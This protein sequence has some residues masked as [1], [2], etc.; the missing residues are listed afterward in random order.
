MK[1]TIILVDKGLFI[2]PISPKG[3]HRLEDLRGFL[4][5][6]GKPISDDVLFSPVDYKRKRFLTY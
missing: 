5:H 1:F 2:R 6:E 3:K 4:K